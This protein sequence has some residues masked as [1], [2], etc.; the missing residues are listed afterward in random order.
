M[1]LE[2]EVAM[3]DPRGLTVAAGVVGAI[4]LVLIAGAG[5][6]SAS[7]LV[8]SPFLPQPPTAPP[9]ERVLFGHVESL[10]RRGSRYELRLDP[11]EFLGGLTANRAAIEDGVIPP[12]DV[13]PNDYYIRDE[14]HRL[15]TYRV[16]GDAHVTIITK[17]VRATR[18]TVAEL[19]QIVRGRNPKHRPLYD[20]RGTLGFWVR[21]AT[22][23]VHSLDQQYQP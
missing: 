11:A 6:R 19:A 7:P 8:K 14:G 1:R 3:R 20:T 23:S 13:V 15:L 4:S 10:A 2:G 12:G 21:V 18:I 5:A 9:A 17:G 16:P 22:D